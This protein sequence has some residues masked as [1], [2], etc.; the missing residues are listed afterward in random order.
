MGIEITVLEVS[1]WLHIFSLW[2]L[3][4]YQ[5]LPLWSCRFRSLVIQR[6]NLLFLCKLWYQLLGAL[7]LP[8]SRCHLCNRYKLR[9]WPEA[10]GRC[11]TIWARFIATCTVGRW[12]SKLFVVLT[13][14]NFLQSL[15]TIANG[16]EW[17]PIMLASRS[18]STDRLTFYAGSIEI[19]IGIW[20]VLG[21]IFI[22]EH[23]V[24]HAVAICH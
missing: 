20:I 9:F 6:G 15:V 4:L 3:L 22:C 14:C 7:H 1:V 16:C 5:C 21:V 12:L 18:K 23:T 2:L 17:L 8:E 11:I 13:H 24:S 10:S 19:I